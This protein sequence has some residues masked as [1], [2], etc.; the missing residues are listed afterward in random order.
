MGFSLITVGMATTLA[1]NKTSDGVIAMKRFLKT[2]AVV[3]A[4]TLVSGVALA[5]PPKG[6]NKTT[7]SNSGNGTGNSINVQNKGGQGGPHK[8][9]T[10]TI[11]DSGNGTGNS[12]NVQNKGGQGGPHKGNTTTITDSGN[13]TGNSINVQNKGGK[14]GN[15]TTVTGS[16][17]GTGNTIS[18]SN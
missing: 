11:T 15:T 3:S 1:P 8:G 18:V 12:I 13:G 7:I 6:G 5:H 10:T 16:G 17:N 2:L 4:L 14:E 9:N